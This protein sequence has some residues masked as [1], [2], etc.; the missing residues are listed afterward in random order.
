MFNEVK[1]VLVPV[2][3]SEC[4]IAA[5]EQALALGAALGAKVE[6]LHTDVYKRQPPHRADCRPASKV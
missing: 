2:D 5:L 1:K 6:V 4:S 3:F